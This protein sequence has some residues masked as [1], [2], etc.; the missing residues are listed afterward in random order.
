MCPIAFPPDQVLLLAPDHPAV[1]QTV[2]LKLGLLVVIN[3]N[4]LGHT[5][6]AHHSLQLAG[7]EDVVHSPLRR[8]SYPPCLT[9]HLPHKVVRSS[10]T[11][12]QLARP[13]F[14]RQVPSSYPDLLP[15]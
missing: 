15:N 1:H 14:Q 3:L 13:M 6:V 12:S 8:D 5:W 10:P 9:A 2:H 7:V 4:R 11:R